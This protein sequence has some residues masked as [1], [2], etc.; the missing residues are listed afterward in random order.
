ME[1]EQGWHQLACFFSAL[2]W[3]STTQQRLS[4]ESL[5][6]RLARSRTATLAL[7][8]SAQLFL[9]TIYFLIPQG[10]F[11]AFETRINIYALQNF[12]LAGLSM[13]M[14]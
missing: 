4:V 3:D 7:G 11:A 5:A 8:T 10:V 12:H 6:A 14:N 13:P 1:G 2:P 9:Y